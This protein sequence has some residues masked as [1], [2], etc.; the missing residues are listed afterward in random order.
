MIHILKK[1]VHLAVRF[2]QLGGNSHEWD[3]EIFHEHVIFLYFHYRHKLFAEEM[4]DVSQDT[5]SSSGSK[6]RRE[7]SETAASS[8][9]TAEKKSAG[10]KRRKRWAVAQL[11]GHFP[12]F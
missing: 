10:S 12:G 4:S 9:T 11:K 5:T 6:R 3:I 2:C 1:N 7:T 8:S